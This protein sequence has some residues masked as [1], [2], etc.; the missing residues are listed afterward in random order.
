MVLLFVSSAGAGGMVGNGGDSILQEFS[1]RGLQ[2]AAYFKAEPTV[3]QTF[4]IDPIKFLDI[5]KKTKL[6]GQDHLFLLAQEVDA[7]NYPSE[8]RIEV[9][10]SRWIQTTSRTDAYLIQ[11]RIA[12]HEY[13]WVYGIN[14]DKYI[15]SNPI[16]V[17]IE[18][19]VGQ[20]LDSET[21]RLFFQRF[22]DKLSAN[23]FVGAGELLSWG[24]DLNQDCPS[25]QASY[26]PMQIILF[27]YMQ[28]PES[29]LIETDRL[30]L[31]KRML[32]FGANPNQVGFFEPIIIDVLSNS[33]EFAKL[34][35]EFGADPNLLDNQ[36][37]S[38]FSQ[39][40]NVTGGFNMRE[41]SFTMFFNA[42]GDVNLS[43]SKFY[44]RSPARVIVSKENNSDVVEALIQTGQVD[45]CNSG[46]SAWI[47]RTIDVVRPEYQSLLDKYQ[48][49]CGRFAVVAGEGNTCL[50]AQENGKQKCLNQGF[51]KATFDPYP[52]EEQCGVRVNPE[53]NE[54]F[55]AM[56][57][58]TDE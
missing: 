45:W 18:K 29:N 44:N 11:R 14:D 25:S 6:E 7:I 51:Q 36:G 20:T 52:V 49:A 50:L 32:Q 1:L 48:I 27:S 13:L 56:F 37:F 47:T 21:Q 8:Y 12:L 4:G 23:D 16:I 35:F 58:C 31:I 5:V 15:I 38:V 53:G 24:L 22:C 40:A 43:A 46:D 41:N 39:A 10:R 57:H 3:A 17:E 9:S 54:E 2:L 55:W 28:K 42:G 19:A 33:L 30:K 26:T 34:L